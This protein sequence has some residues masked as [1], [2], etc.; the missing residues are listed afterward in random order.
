MLTRADLWSLE[1]YAQQRASF[2]V[3]AMARKRLRTV[4]VG[5]HL[6]LL[7]EDEMTVRY[8]VQEM[9]RIER[10]FEPQAIQDELDAYNPLIPD[11]HN[12]KATLLIEYADVAERVARLR[13]L[14]GVEK[15]VGLR[16]DGFSA[17]YPVADE[18]MIRASAEKT[19][20]VHFL[21]YEV[22]LDQRH[23]LREGALLAVG[24]D[25]AAYAEPWSW[26]TESQR[27]AL[28]QDLHD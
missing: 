6:T 21:R 16:V 27:L 2:R 20:A 1:A 7:F 11:G 15:R 25:H 22:P 14:L 19:S 26:L 13:A 24:V 8:Q 5:D 9:L 18:D 23:A 28:L 12:W 10:I 3:Q 17:M 4:P